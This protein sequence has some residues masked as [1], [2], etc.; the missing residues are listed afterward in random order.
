MRAVV[1]GK[2]LCASP[3]PHRSSGYEVLRGARAPQF[4]VVDQLV[5]EELHGAVRGPG[6]V[7]REDEIGPSHIEQRVT[8]GRR[9]DGQH[10]KSCTADQAFVERLN[11]RR[12][13]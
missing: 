3:A 13:V 7:W 12:L 2:T 1:R 4:Y 8:F 6:D 10:I 11:Q 5:R 9:L